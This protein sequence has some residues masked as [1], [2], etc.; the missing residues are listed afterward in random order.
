LTDAVFKEIFEKDSKGKGRALGDI[1]SE[2]KNKSGAGENN[3]KFA[4][5]G[6]PSQRLAMPFYSV[7]TTA[8]N[9]KSV[10]LGKPDTIKALQKVTIQGAI[11]DAQGNVVT[12]FNGKVFPS[13]YDKAV[14]LKTLGQDNTASFDFK[15]QKNILFRGTATVK[16]GIFTFSCVLPKDIN[17]D[18]G[19]GK[20]SYYAENG[21]EDAS[22]S[23][24]TNL[25]I[26]GTYGLAKDDLPPKI[27]IFMNN[28]NFIRGGLTN[29]NPTLLV[30]L[31]DDIGLNMS[32]TSV[33]HDF[34]AILDNNPQNTFRLNNFYEAATDDP[35]QGS[36]KFPLARLA[37]GT[38]IIKVKAWD[39]ANNSAENE[40]EFVVENSASAALEHILNY[41]NPFTTS[42]Q[43]QFDHN[44]SAPILDVQV[45][46]Y[47][48]AGRLVKVIETQVNNTGRAQV[49]WDGKDDVGDDL[50]KGVY[51]YK[52]LVKEEGVN[53]KKIDSEFEKLVILK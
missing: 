48:I 50:A 31:S 28:E 22:G 26:G 24:E 16:N 21:T 25:V 2:A 13:I 27:K 7:K 29:Q 37:A 36:A 41:P 47:T 3:R 45:K 18:Y 42:T 44:L 4:L 11:L 38:H 46:I 34:T 12:S 17:Y 32:G 6:D 8:I 40:T 14:K 30:K 33:G 1:L 23:D 15:I 5:L 51:L 20:I 53:G 39:L 35:T 9:G 49:P 19:F 43:F 10:A 52:L